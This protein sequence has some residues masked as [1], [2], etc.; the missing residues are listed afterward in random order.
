MPAIPLGLSAYKRADL[1]RVLLKNMYYERTAANLEDQIAILSRPRLK[2]FAVYGTGPVRGTFRKG[3]VLAL[4]GRSGSIISLSGNDLY[5]VVQAGLPGVGTAT[6]IGTVEGAGRMS[7]EGSLSWVVL[8]CGTKAYK[9]DG[10]TMSQI[11]MPDDRLVSAVDTLD[12]RFI[13]ASEPGRFYWTDPAGV[14]VNALSFATAESQPDA[15]TTLKVIVDELWLFG[16][17]SIEVW[18]PTGDQDLPFQ[19]IGGRIF[20]I[21]CTARDTCQKL[22]VAGRDV[23]CWVGTDRIVYQTAP[24]PVRISHNGIEEMLRQANPTNLSAFTFSWTGHDF[25]ALHIPEFG[26]F[27]FDL[28]TQCWLQL[29][30]YGRTLFRCGTTAEG[31][32]SQPLLGDDTLGVLYEFSTDVRDD[33]GD[34]V[35]FEFSGLIEVTDG[36]V[37]CKN[38]EVECSTGLT[39][40]PKNDPMIEMATSDDHGEVF[41]EYEPQALQR[42]GN[43]AQRIMWSRLAFMRREGG[44]L[45][46]WRTA[47]P[48]TVRKA[49]YNASYR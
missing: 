6:L 33:N 8:T 10:A 23:V 38:V 40:D 14:T 37:Q 13:F 11:A 2:Q 20:G 21:G 17:L 5:R 32:D 7:A 12:S 47:E 25:Y 16:R 15:L 9:T 34:K 44:R 27:V 4:V 3:G 41:D 42:Q 28:S 18:Q 36:P 43:R 45:F 26:T 35:L 1:P 22:K 24:N 19:R 39:P 31:P 30:S 49:K 46:R 48:I 29:T